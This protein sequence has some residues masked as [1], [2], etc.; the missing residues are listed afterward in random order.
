MEPATIPGDDLSIHA[1]PL[2][3]WRRCVRV[4]S[5]ILFGC[6][7]WAIP[8]VL[9]FGAFQGRF[10][11]ALGEA[12]LVA[13]ALAIEGVAIGSIFR[14]VRPICRTP[15]HRLVVGPLVGIASGAI[16]AFLLPVMF[17]GMQAIA[18]LSRYP[19]AIV[20]ICAPAALFGYRAVALAYD[21]N[22]PRPAGSIWTRRLSA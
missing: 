13:L 20:M 18:E 19:I 5:L 10:G 3:P 14:A 6:F 1:L 11:T 2:V 12:V 8:A 17:D 16:C 21:A 22:A 7:G 9:I 4:A 15:R